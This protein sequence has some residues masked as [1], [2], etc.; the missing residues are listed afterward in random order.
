MPSDLVKA[1]FTPKSTWRTSPTTNQARIDFHHVMLKR[2]D[3]IKPPATVIHVSFHENPKILA[4][5]TP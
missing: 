5:C 3:V 4:A 1:V 2:K